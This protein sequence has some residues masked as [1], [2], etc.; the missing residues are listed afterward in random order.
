MNVTRGIVGAALVACAAPV[1]AQ[2]AVAYRLLATNKTSTMAKE[3]NEAAEAGFRF[4]SA[5]GGDTSMGGNQ[6]VVVMARTAA[7]PARCSYRLLATSRTSTMQRELQ[8]A[9]D[10]GFVYRGQTV[11]KTAFGGDEV[12][13]ILERDR[14]QP[15][16][17]QQYK[18]LA[19]RKT[20]TL[21]KELNEA[22]ELGYEL[23]GLT[24]AKTAMGGE[25]V[26]A[27]TR[28]ARP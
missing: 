8:E 21:Q 4:A 28:R 1:W 19:T 12:V 7:D 2:D 5:M 27:I 14:D 17:E 22:G 6:V 3:M 23:M 15:A 11:F 13:V 25:E 10:D 20:G 18:L 24:V 26:V 16:G 9:G